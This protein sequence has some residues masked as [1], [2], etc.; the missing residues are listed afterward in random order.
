MSGYVTVQ[1]DTATI[2][3]PEFR[4][5]LQYGDGVGTDPR[6][7]VECSNALTT[8]GVLRPMACCEQLPDTLADPIETLAR[9][10]RRYYSADD[11]KDVLIAAAGGQLY[12]RVPTGEKWKRIPMP[13]TYPGEEYQCSQWSCVSY[14]INP[15]DSTSPVDVLLMSNARDGMI[16][17]RGDD[18]TA[19]PV[20]TPKKF[21][22]IARHAERIWGGAIAQE[23]DMLVYSA[24]YDPF[25]W[26]Q[27]SEIPEDGAG[28]V[29]QPSWDGDSFT[30]LTSFGSQLIAFKRNRL[31]RVL[32]TDPGQYV[33][34][35]QY[36]GG[37]RYER[38]I[39]V[40]TTRI[41]MLGR[42]G[43]WQYD[44]ESVTA[45]QQ[46]YAQAVFE[47]MNADA[48]DQASACI[49]RDTY[50]CALPLDDSRSNNA[51]LLYNMKEKTWLLRENVD[52]ETFLPAE[53]ALFFTSAKAP[54]VLW[55]WQEDCM[56]AGSAAPM[57][58]VSAWHD[59]G[60]HNMVKGSFSVY[61]TV[62]CAEQTVL[63]VGVETE[64][65]CKM[66]KLT[67][68]PSSPGRHAR[69]RKIAFGG[70]GRRFRLVIESH[71]KIPWRLLGGVQVE[72]ETD[73][74]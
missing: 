7:A 12:W 26:K 45:Y 73:V 37:A 32:G 58:W 3:I 34:K 70:S 36:G 48:L 2:R 47:R 28:D 55:K 35:E 38:T 66:K 44:G 68:A 9:L 53:D 6:F 21:G 16:C 13:P 46:E 60:Y 17:I 74:D 54:G 5:L 14:E 52:V 41:M 72:A 20:A 24:P 62:E 63:S 27:N 8:G 40:D 11:E 67:F 15:E 18:L 31:W 71:G 30:A 61:L 64:K 56:T 1:N 43:L 23:P 59:L 33:F 19:Y 29:L 69:Q 50:Y 25:D 39:A 65:K 4:G 10:H 42:E 49:W 51:V 22:V 57:R